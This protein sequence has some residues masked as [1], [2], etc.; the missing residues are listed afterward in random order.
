MA[1][2]DSPSANTK[3]FREYLADR[4][5]LIADSSGTA[6]TG[7]KK[8][9]IDMGAKQHNIFV[10][11]TFEAAEEV[12]VK[13]QPQI[14]VCDYMLGRKCGLDL[15]QK[16][17]KER[18]EAKDTLFALVTGST[19]QSTV[20]QAAEEDVDTFILK[21]YTVDMLR[22]A[23]M[24][25]ALTKQ[26]PSEYQKTIDEG[27]KLLVELKVDEAMAIFEKAKGMDPKPA[28]ACFYYGQ[29]E[30][31][32]KLLDDARGSYSE[33]LEFSKIHFKCLTGLFDILMEQKLH[34]DAY[35][36]VKRVARYFPANPHRLAQVLR[37]AIMTQ[38]FEDIESYYKNF[39]E[40][41][42][43]NEV[44]IKTVC[45]SLIVCG[46]FY[47]R[48]SS[49][50]RALELFT[51]AGTTAGG[52][53]HLIKEIILS[54][55]EYDLPKEA[56]PFL[57]RFPPD[58][59]G[60]SDFL[61][62]EY[63]VADRFLDPQ[64]SVAKGRSLLSKKVMDPIIHKTLTRRLLELG[65]KDQAETLMQ[66]AIKTWPDKQAMFEELTSPKKAA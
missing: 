62:V 54:L 26:Y 10:A 63:L 60:G 59:Q 27:K 49:H 36:V 22:N 51:K 1:K 5:V 42:E 19:S 18:P 17:K 4:K 20:A 64:S 66:E 24:K 31:M 9:F 65:Y 43:R 48:R 50:S 6:R 41:D 12:I 47:L 34:N 28:L 11:G 52:R 56:E 8:T 7:L 57:K 44:L 53:I 35:E 61:S 21:P 39:M 3:L 30:L 14:V 40:L 37:L 58:T 38:K 46:K 29:A 15:I 45:A 13:S 32:K 2:I 23:L 55:I 25:A 16:Q 33:G